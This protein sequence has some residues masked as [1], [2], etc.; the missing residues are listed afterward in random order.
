MAQDTDLSLPVRFNPFKHHWH[1]ILDILE[2]ASPE[3]ILS[4]LGSLC[5]NYIDI[6]TGILTPE[7]IGNAIVEI[8][9]S[10]QAF[11]VDDFARWVASGNGYQLIQLEDQS[12]WVVRKSN[13]YKRYIHLH[14]ARTGPL[15]TRYKGSSL[16]TLYMLKASYKDFPVSLSLEKINITRMQIGLSP[17]KKFDR[18]IG[19][20][21][22]FEQF[23]SKTS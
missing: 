15:M 3:V 11:E 2:S 20:L 7:A 12:E 19:L 22:C 8:I 9:K 16:K 21:K 17:V 14:P 5:N 18:N 6:Y 23:F 13:E 1:Y 4:L 10:K